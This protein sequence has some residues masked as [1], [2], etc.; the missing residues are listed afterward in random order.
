MFRVNTYLPG[1]LTAAGLGE[2]QPLQKSWDSTAGEQRKGLVH[3]TS[4]LRTFLSQ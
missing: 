3:N 2:I 4:A 1:A